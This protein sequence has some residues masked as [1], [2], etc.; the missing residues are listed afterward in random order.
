MLS[1]EPDTGLNLTTPRSPPK[2]KS[3]AYLIVPPRYLRT[4]T[5]FMESFQCL[6]CSLT[7][8]TWV[9]SLRRTLSLILSCDLVWIVLSDCSTTFRGGLARDISL[10]LALVMFPKGSFIFV[11]LKCHDF[12][13]LDVLVF[14]S[15][16]MDIYTWKIGINLILHLLTDQARSLI[17][18][19]VSFYPKPSMGS[20]AFK[21]WLVIDRW[22]S[23]A[24][25]GTSGSVGCHE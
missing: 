14:S 3:R 20:V 18:C 21:S 17:S 4:F 25:A 6:Y 24:S 8:G 9:L 19:G 10:P 1:S 12:Q 7:V 11:S 15:W 23:A 5:F 13:V 16:L 2:P 22:S